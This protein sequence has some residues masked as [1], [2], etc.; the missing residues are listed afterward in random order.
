MSTVIN[1]LITVGITSYNAEDTIERC[2]LSALSQTWSPFEVVVVDDCSHDETLNIVN[3]ISRNLSNIR[4]FI[5]STNGGVAFSRNRIIKEANG[6]FIIFF[7][8]DDESLPDRI[9]LQY[10]RILD[11]EKQ[12]ARGAPVICHT[13]RTLRYPSGEVRFEQTMGQILLKTAP[14]GPAVARRIL[15]GQPLR[16]GYGACPACSQMARLSTYRLIGGFDQS[17]RR[18]EDTD[19]NIRLAL[20]GGHFVG[21]AE[22]LVIQNMTKTSEKNLQVEYEYMKRLLNKHRNFMEQAGQFN[23]SLDWLDLKQAWMKNHHTVFTKLLFKLIFLH[24]TLTIRRLIFAVPN[25]GLNKAF[26]HF[27]SDLPR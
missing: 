7:D 23:F 26:S 13:A 24:P 22:P 10:K 27:H 3:R 6:E 14:S 1:P 8:D 4:V 11:Y 21:I 15:F 25:I 12:F 9:A 17:L 18:G 19:F 20:A 16:D 2:I 5:N